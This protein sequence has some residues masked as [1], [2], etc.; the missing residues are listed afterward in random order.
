MPDLIPIGDEGQM[1]QQI[2]P[3]EVCASCKAAVSC[4]LLA[5]LRDYQIM[6]YTGMAIFR[7]VQY[8]PDETSPNYVQ[9]EYREP[10]LIL[11]EQMAEVQ[12]ETDQLILDLTQARGD[13]WSSLN[14]SA[15]RERARPTEPWPRKSA[16]NTKESAETS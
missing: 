12:R 2:W 9:R 3:H 7:C 13:L 8:E 1:D 14:L 4:P 10:D 16:K 11:A 5:M 6:T 15:I